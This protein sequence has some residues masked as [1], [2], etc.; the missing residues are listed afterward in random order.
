MINADSPLIHRQ[1]IADVG[2]DRHGQVP[3]PR[4]VPLAHHDIWHPDERS[5]CTPQ[6]LEV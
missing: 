1:T 2:L 4:E 6:I 5:Q 3:M